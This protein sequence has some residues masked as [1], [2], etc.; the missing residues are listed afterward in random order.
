MW[1]GTIMQAS[2]MPLCQCAPFQNNSTRLCA[3]PEPTPGSA[4]HHGPTVPTSPSPRACSRPLH[5]SAQSQQPHGRALLGG[6][7]A[8]S[9]HSTVEPAVLSVL[10]EVGA[11]G[12]SPRTL[13]CTGACLAAGAG[14]VLLFRGQTDTL[15]ITHHWESCALSAGLVQPWL[16][17]PA[18]GTGAETD[19]LELRAPSLFLIQLYSLL[20]S[21]STP[22]A[23]LGPA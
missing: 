3:S 11:P 4:E 18:L 19:S 17:A 1:A 23:R 6:R 13:C 10:A 12:G 8:W 16:P 5:A 20:L 14:T 2:H 22:G 7:G 15:A 9:P 21:C